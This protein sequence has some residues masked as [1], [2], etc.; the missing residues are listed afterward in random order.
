MKIASAGY[1]LLDHD[2]HTRRISPWTGTPTP[3]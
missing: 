1:V 3:A 2:G